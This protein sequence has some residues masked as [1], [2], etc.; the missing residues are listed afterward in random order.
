MLDR[1]TIEHCLEFLGRADL[2]GREVPAF[3]NVSNRLNHLHEARL[4]E[5]KAAAELA[6]NPPV[7]PPLPE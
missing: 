6:A 5:E 1:Q 7:E 4:A 2:K 3:V